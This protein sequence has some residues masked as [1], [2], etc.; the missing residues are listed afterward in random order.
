MTI[1]SVQ[2]PVRVLILVDAILLTREVTRSVCIRGLDGLI[3]C[4]EYEVF[5]VINALWLELRLAVQISAEEPPIAK[6]Q[7]NDS[8]NVTT[9]DPWNI[10]GH[11]RCMN[12]TR[13]SVQA[14]YH[15]AVR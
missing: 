8:T 5:H 1:L 6:F 4:I 9:P 11:S 13:V 14:P 10:R 12:I 15:V 3:P 2:I 7:V